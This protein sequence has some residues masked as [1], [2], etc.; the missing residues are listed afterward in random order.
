MQ[1]KYLSPHI[2][3]KFL[4]ILSTVRAPAQIFLHVFSHI[5]RGRR[6]N[7]IA[8]KRNSERLEN[9]CSNEKNDVWDICIAETY[10]HKYIFLL[11]LSWRKTAWWPVS[12]EEERLE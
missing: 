5:I 4:I 1:I 2:E 3:N 7:A 12:F 6:L 10:V 8:N 9:Q 11:T